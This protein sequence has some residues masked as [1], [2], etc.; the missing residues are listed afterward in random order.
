MRNLH[1]VEKFLAE[2]PEQHQHS[3][4]PT[5]LV[6]DELAQVVAALLIE[7]YNET[8]ELF[9]QL[10]GKSWQEVKDFLSMA[11]AHEAYD[12]KYGAGYTRLEDDEWG[13]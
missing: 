1:P 9:P 12:K 13:S 3:D 7:V 10:Q 2:Q 6:S 4:L 8:V 5:H 11:E